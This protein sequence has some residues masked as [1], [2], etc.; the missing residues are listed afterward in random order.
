MH[1]SSKDNDLLPLEHNDLLQIHPDL[2]FLKDDSG[3]ITLTFH[4][5]NWAFFRFF[6]V[7]HKA[8]TNCKVTRKRSDLC[9]VS[10]A[11]TDNDSV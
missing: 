5:A 7:L 4:L 9:L 8:A 6:W 11:S 1:E 10:F 3:G 2:V